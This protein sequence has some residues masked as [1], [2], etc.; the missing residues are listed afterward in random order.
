MRPEIVRQYMVPVLLVPLLLLACP[1]ATA[2]V[3]ELG[4]TV[5]PPSV[6]ERGDGT[7]RVE[8]DGLRLLAEPGA[9]LLPVLP[10][11]LVLPPG[12]V[13]HSVRVVP[14]PVAFFETR[15]TVVHARQPRKRSEP[16]DSHVPTPPDE[17]IYGSDAFS[18]ASL[19]ADPVSLRYR[20]FGLVSVML[21]PVRCRPASGQ[22]AWNRSMKLVLTTRPAA[23]G[24]SPLPLLSLDEGTLARVR[25]L[26]DNPGAV[27]EYLGLVPTAG[28]GEESRRS[29]RGWDQVIITSPALA[30][31]FEALA[32]WKT[33][34]GLR[35][36]VV[37][38][39][40][41]YAQFTEGPE[42]Q[43]I[44][45]FIT[46][47]YESWGTRS[48]LLGGDDEV[49][50]HRGFMGDEIFYIDL[51][52]P[53]DLY[54][55]ALDGTWNDDNDQYWGE[56]GEADYLPEVRVGR[57]PVDSVAEAENFTAKLVRYQEAPVLADCET[58]LMIGEE[59]WWEAKARDYKEEIRL[60]SDNWGFTTAG[61][62]EEFLVG[63]IYDVEGVWD[64]EADLLPLL[65]RGP[66]LINHAGHADTYVVMKLSDFMITP[67]NLTADGVENGL[68]I[69]YSQGCYCGAFDNRDYEFNYLAED[70]AG[71]EL[72]TIPTGAVACVMNSRNGWGSSVD[73]NG[74]SQYFDREFFDALFGEGVTTLGE[75]FDDSK[76]DNVDLVGN[77]FWRY[78][79][80]TLNL[81]G[82]P[83]LQVWTAA[84][85]PLQVWHAAE[86]GMG[87]VTVPLRVLRDGVPLAG[88]RVCLH[89]PGDGG[90]Y[91]RGETNDDGRVW[92]PVLLSSVEPLRVSVTGPN[93]L[94]HDSTITPRSLAAWIGY[95]NCQVDDDDSG[96]SSGDGNGVAGN[97]ETLELHVAVRNFGLQPADGVSAQLSGDSP[98]YTIVS[99]TASYGDIEPGAS[100]VSTAPF[101]VEVYGGVLDGVEKQL[102][103]T[104]T[105]SLGREW[106]SSFE[107]PLSAP[108]IVCAGVDVVDVG[109]NGTG[110]GNG[111]LEPG[112]T[113][114]VTLTAGNHG[115]R[116]AGGLLAR[117]VSQDPLVEVLTANTSFGDV[118]AGESA[119]AA[120]PLT[121]RVAA[122]AP[123]PYH[124][125]LDVGFKADWSFRGR[126]AFG[127]DVV[128]LGLEEDMEDGG[129]GW[130][131]GPVKWTADDWRLSSQ[132]AAGGDGQ[133]WKCGP[134]AVW[135]PYSDRMDAGLVSPPFGLQPGS[136]LTFWHAM[137]AEYMETYEYTALDGGIVEISVDRGP[138]EALRPLGG[139]EMTIFP[140]WVPVAFPTDT[141]CFSGLFEGRRE[142][143]YLDDRQGVARVR[144]RFGS[145]HF[146]SGFPEYRG[147]FVD[148]VAVAPAAGPV[149]EVAPTCAMTLAR[150]VD[151]VTADWVLANHGT[152]PVEGWAMVVL[153]QEPFAGGPVS[154]VVEPW[155]LTLGP[156]EAVRGSVDWPIPMAH[157]WD[158]HR[159]LVRLA[160]S[161]WG[162]AYAEDSFPISIYGE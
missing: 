153:V 162:A 108:L 77:S 73:T 99:G 93:S 105:D 127:L 112:E 57:A 107:L 36:R 67:E 35:C 18:P 10:V 143:V 8:A 79:Y 76:I 78:C 97:G 63:T 129:P 39:P 92:L 74:P 89:Q 123:A 87:S 131:H 23:D 144:F 58:G 80:Y 151:A 7:V 157:G 17:R 158:R 85:Q 48:V 52:L 71:E 42:Q 86:V 103:L 113:A 30:A 120:T 41:I 152:E 62:P 84:P 21:H 65:A 115:S 139:Y 44:R 83:E 128:A 94:P 19:H 137:D 122:E 138:W 156:G 6:L 66:N 160:P 135:A 70:A 147:W 136:V 29:S 53:A 101:V 119:A 56:P 5:P 161:I 133:A 26:A 102:T 118:P 121:I 47:A 98:A 68:S 134:A 60:G 20:G 90:A 75:V 22:V 88:A 37:T 64:A 116:A 141:R 43:R 45:D 51:D 148:D 59:T 33:G 27:D 61:F 124:P 81:L 142:T 15:G 154:W 50:P 28:G 25:D 91:A 95:E 55:A 117:V 149:A 109:G 16:R 1:A 159:L 155:P 49:V 4:V 145:D 54:Y 110:A 38:L 12:E 82:D 100:A 9:P 146:K 32:A 96:P 11:T 111:I 130:T 125:S 106:V 114:E 13:L 72:V 31:P 14:G 3:V 104:V 140:F 69:I 34:R 46:M 40:Q 2:E 24:E 150:G 132:Y 126:S